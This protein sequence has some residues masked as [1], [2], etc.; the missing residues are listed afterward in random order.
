[1]KK[2]ARAIFIAKVL[3]LPQQTMGFIGTS[4]HRM[5]RRL[6]IPTLEPART[7]TSCK[8]SRDNMAPLNLVDE[9]MATTSDALL[10]DY[11]ITDSKH[12]TERPSIFSVINTPR[13]FVSLTLVFVGL[14][15]S[16][17]N[18]VGK[19]DDTYVSLESTAI[20]LGF[21]S[22]FAYFAEVVSGTNISKNVRRGIVDDATVTV[23][24][25]CYTA[26]VSWLALRTSES[27]PDW[28]IQ[29]DSVLPFMS[30]GVFLFS[31]IAPLLTL[32][33]NFYESDRKSET[34]S[35]PPYQSI[36]KF[37]RSLS[38]QNDNDSSDYY[39]PATLSD[40]ELLRANGL[41][42]IGV[43]ACVF[44]PDALSFALGS[45]SWWERVTTIH[46]SQKMLESSTSIFALLSVEASMLSHRVGKT[47]AASFEVIVPAFVIVCSFLAIL[48]CI[49]AL[50]WLGD[51]V[52]FFSFYRE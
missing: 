26:A 30:I 44:A 38:I 29:F 32:S 2:A 3:N 7:W 48:P 13:E 6:T 50:H 33:G 20:T 17:C 45:Q 5:V 27:C 49:C 41:L 35:I 19:Y 46:P 4:E 23:Y 22:T 24:A 11:L 28:I 1:M 52:S 15:I 51:D 8:G 36:V 47:G 43:L 34:N 18:V 10:D 37:S 9:K 39:E 25:A 31:L 42:A 12:L 14:L 40:T 16:A 21:V